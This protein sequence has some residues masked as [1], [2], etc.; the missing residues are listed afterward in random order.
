MKKNEPKLIEL[1]HKIYCFVSEDQINTKEYV[2]I[3][4]MIEGN[5]DF[6]AEITNYIL[7]ESSLN[8]KTI[9]MIL[10]EEA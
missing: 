6:V 8:R 4:D 1:S 2:E 10:S 7:I 3:E 5:M 9:Q